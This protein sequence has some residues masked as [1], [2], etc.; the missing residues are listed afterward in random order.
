MITLPEKLETKRLV[1][2]PLEPKD[3]DG[4]LR[5]MTDS[6]ATR[7]LLF[8]DEQRT[9]RGARELFDFVMSSYSG[10]NPVFAYAIALR[11]NDR[12]IGSCG[13]SDLETFAKLEC[14]YALLPEYWKRGFATEATKALI[15]YCAGQDGVSEIWAFMS[16][17]NP[18]S[19]GVAE[20]AGMKFC[21]LNVHPANGA[22]GLAYV[23][24]SR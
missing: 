20:R 4:F 19:A 13:V 14:Y 24:S 23:Y 10:D 21:G 15:H 1:I 8:S 6:E 5:F 9:E 16:R 7:Y 3:L 11:K 18:N 22:E 17:E 2:R 12:F